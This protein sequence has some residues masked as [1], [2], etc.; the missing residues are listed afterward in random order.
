[1]SQIDKVASLVSTLETDINVLSYAQNI[2][3]AIVSGPANHCAATLSALLVFFGIYPYG[4]FSGNGDLQP[5]VP[6]LAFDLQSR[7]GWSQ[8]ASGAAIESGDVGVVLLS[9]GVHHIYLVVD[10]TDQLQPVIADNQSPNLHMRT[11][12][13]DP[14]QNWSPTSYF[15]RAPAV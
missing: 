1:M 10:A 14:A 15:L 11:V 3:T 5:W 9:S 8:V 6:T 2:A 13:G 4:A 12:A 7:Q